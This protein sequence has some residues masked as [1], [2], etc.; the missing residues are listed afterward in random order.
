[1]VIFLI[2]YFILCLLVDIL[3]KE[4]LSPPSLSL[5]TEKC[6]FFK[7]NQKVMSMDLWVCILLNGLLAIALSYLGPRIAPG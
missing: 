4:N 5:C 1:M 6:V 3:L 2:Q 7:M